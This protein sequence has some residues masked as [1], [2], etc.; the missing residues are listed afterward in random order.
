[1]FLRFFI[2]HPSSDAIK[3]SELI[4]ETSNLPYI[5]A[6]D[7][8]LLFVQQIILK[9]GVFINNILQ[10]NRFLQNWTGHR[11]SHFDPHQ[12]KPYKIVK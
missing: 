12:K 5:W 4:N 11:R 6:K 1:M 2:G 9:T 10:F 8:P 3:L 7:A